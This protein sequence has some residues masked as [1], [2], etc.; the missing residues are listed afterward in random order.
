MKVNKSELDQL[1]KSAIGSGPARNA[2]A[3]KFV[4]SAMANP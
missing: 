4:R 3:P 2:D 1:V